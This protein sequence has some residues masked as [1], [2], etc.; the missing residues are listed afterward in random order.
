MQFGVPGSTSGRKWVA[1]M[2]LTV[3]ALLMTGIWI[4][5]PA[6][7]AVVDVL[8]TGVAL[9]YVSAAAGLLSGA[10]WGQLLARIASYV[11]LG[12]GALTVTLLSMSAAQLAGLYGPV[13]SGG[14]LLLGTV[15][16]LV[17]PYLVALPGVQ[18]ALLRRGH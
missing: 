17:L 1:A 3:A 12:L 7:Y 13:G 14:A 9:L 5:L 15:A 4:A 10:R 16:L 11:A 6:R 2:Q 18:L 8:G